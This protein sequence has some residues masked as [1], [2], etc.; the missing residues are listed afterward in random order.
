MSTSEIK[1]PLIGAGASILALAGLY[2]SIRSTRSVKEESDEVVAL[3]GDVG[4]TNVRFTLRKLN[5]KTRTSVEIKELTKFPSQEV[6][7][8]EA[9][10]AMFIK[11]S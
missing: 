6:K 10:V 3:I 5:M 7:S 9:A 4:G 2:Y 8:I 11:V 1:W